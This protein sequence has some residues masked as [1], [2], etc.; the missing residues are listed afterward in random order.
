MPTAPA[1]AIPLAFR[2][3]SAGTASGGTALCF[4]FFFSS[5]PP[6]SEEEYPFGVWTLLWRAYNLKTFRGVVKD[7]EDSRGTLAILGNE[8]YF[9]YFFSD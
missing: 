2:L 8:N 5:L 1:P 4:Y 9:N 7:H 3:P 6:G